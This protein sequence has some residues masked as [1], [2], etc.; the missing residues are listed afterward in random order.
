MMRGQL[1]EA[2]WVATAAHEGNIK[3]P[4]VPKRSDE[5][6]INGL[7]DKDYDSQ[8]Y[9]HFHA[10]PSHGQLMAYLHCLILTWIP[11]WARISS[12]KWVQ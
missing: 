2:L 3:P 6:L 4:V 11:I 8:G 7:I 9:V 5:S 10:K 12:Q 1:K